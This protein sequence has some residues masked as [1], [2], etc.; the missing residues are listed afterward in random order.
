MGRLMRLFAENLSS[1][2]PVTTRMINWSGDSGPSADNVPLRIAG[3]LHALVLLKKAPELAL[4]YPPNDAT[5]TA[6]WQA[7]EHCTHTRE[8]FSQRLDQQPAPNQ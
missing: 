6:L 3:G 5:D 1:V 2:S 4:V 8:R 7:V